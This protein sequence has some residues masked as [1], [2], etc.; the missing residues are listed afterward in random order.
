MKGHLS[1][2]AALGMVAMSFLVACTGATA[3][4]VRMGEAAHKGT[5]NYLRVGPNT[6]THIIEKMRQ[7]TRFQVVGQQ[8]DYYAV[9][10]TNGTRGWTYITNVHFL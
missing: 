2:A 9:I 4:Q 7:G 6:H 3:Q 5:F 10:L 8:G 1:K